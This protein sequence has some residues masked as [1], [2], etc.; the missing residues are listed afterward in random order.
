MS[1]NTDSDTDSDTDS[2]EE[3]RPKHAIEGGE[4]TI[5][6]V[7][8]LRRARDREGEDDDEDERE[9][10]EGGTGAEAAGD[11]QANPPEG[12]SD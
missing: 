4:D 12:G 10:T 5:R 8:R 7:N 2:G 11:D 9:R 6:K 1:E 3:P